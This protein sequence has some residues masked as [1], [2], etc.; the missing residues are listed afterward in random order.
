[1]SRS[2]HSSP[3][4][5]HELIWIL[6][7]DKDSVALYK[8]TLGLQYRLRILESF[9]Q[10]QTEL[11]AQPPTNG[12]GSSWLLITDPEN[13]KKPMKAF[14]SGAADSSGVRLP[15][16]MIVSNVDDL[17]LIRFYLKAGARDYL[18]KPIRPN[19]LV[20]KVEKALQSINNREILIL[21]NDL[22]GLQINNLTFKEHQLLTVFLS[23]DDRAVKRSDLYGAIWN[24]VNV[25]RKTL[26]VHLF[27]LRRKLRPHGYDILCQAQ[28]FSLRKQV[29]EDLSSS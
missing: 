8:Q 17:D 4:S 12:E 28:I 15:E 18:L 9:E 26:D 25:N 21:R 3:A 11:R 6:D 5:Q 14:F 16:C 27:N 20:A 19:E 7:D 1:M 24:K 2:P 22:D 29:E 13:I 23:R 10:L